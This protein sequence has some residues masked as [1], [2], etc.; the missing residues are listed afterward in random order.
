V[1]KHVIVILLFSCLT[2]GIA[3]I[4]DLETRRAAFDVVQNYPYIDEMLLE[5]S[6]YTQVE[7]TDSSILSE[8]VDHFTLAYTPLEL[9]SLGFDL[10][11]D[12]SELAVYFEKDSFSMIVENKTTGYFWSTRPE[13]QGSSGIRE[14]NTASRNLMNSGLWIEY[15]RSANVSTSTTTTAS[16]YSLAEVKYQNDASI[17]PENPDH[18]RPFQLE[19]GSYST[20]KV[21]TTIQNQTTTSFNVHVELLVINLTFD[22][23]ISLV[24]GALEVYIPAESILETGEIYRLLGIQV[25]PYFGASREDKMPGYLMIPDGIG[26]LVRTNQPYNTYFQARFY[27]SDFGY[28]GGT[29]PTL[30]VPIFGVVHEAGKNG[31]YANVIEGAENA[32][33][34]STFWGNNTRYHRIST[35]YLVRQIYKNIINQAG[36]GNDAINEEKTSSNFRIAYRFLSNEEASYIGMAKDYRNYLLEIGML[37]AREKV[38]NGDIPM[39]LSYIMSDQEPSFLGTSPVTM[40]TPIQVQTAYDE[41]K[42]LGILNQ[43]ITLMGWSK[44]GFINQAPYTTRIPDKKNYEALIA[45]V[46]ADGNTLYLSNDYVISSELAARISYNRDVAKNVSRL[47][48]VWEERTLNGQITEMY[49]LY[50][51]RSLIFATNDLVFFQK[52]GVSGLSLSSLGTSL[53]S[54]MDGGIIERSTSVALYQQIAGLYDSLTLYTPNVYL[55][56]YIDGYLDMP[57]TNSQYDYY[58]DLVPILPIILKGSISYYTPYLNFNALAEDRLLTMVDFGVNP[59]YI[60]TGQPTYEMRYTPASAFYTTTLADYREEIVAT[61]QYVN[62]ALSLVTGATIEDREVIS[63]GLVAVTYSNGVIIYVNYTY[64]SQTV[65]LVT[66]LAR[67]YQVVAQ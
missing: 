21:K 18:L 34:L 44:D 14:D 52:L 36:D 49:F 6:R 15:V 37:D 67:S 29:I 19:A 43:Q 13:F 9:D 22:V 54:Y 41:F 40:T 66:V 35:R 33:L 25:F 30:S 47:K 53:V 50:P 59:S 48:I 5:S 61:Y 10:M 32:T 31:Y 12:T 51:Q 7:E 1:V 60:L 57:I 26:A 24:D 16:L 39:Q 20:R 27:G 4:A 56:P 28:Q 17:T 23:Q 42:T 62:D 2:V 65:G 64:A 46:L 8:Y 45:H 38:V 63:T 58:T 11:F 3:G 55:Y